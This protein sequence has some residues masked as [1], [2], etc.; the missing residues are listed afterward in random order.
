[1][2]SRSRVLRSIAALSVV[3]VVG[4][5]P[6]ASP[7]TAPAHDH[8]ATTAAVIDDV[9]E[10]E[11]RALKLATAP[12]RDFRVAQSA[13]FSTQITP[14]FEQLPVGG[15]G[16]HWGDVSRFDASL[17]PSHPEVL[18]Y[19]R[20]RGGAMVLVGVE[21]IVPF[22]AWNSATPPQLFGQT[23][24][25]NL[26]FNVWALHAWIWRPNPRGMFADWNPAVRC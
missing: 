19:E 12:Y 1:M 24:S 14:C 17:D 11:L 26:T 16:F 21:Y 7:A 5:D 22:S 20:Q 10:R 9:A 13:G 23:F 3:A 25:R 8:G 2:H 6:P 4:C 15:M 18:L